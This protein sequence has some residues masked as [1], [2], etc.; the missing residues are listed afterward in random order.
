M[1]GLQLVVLAWGMA[2]FLAVAFI[3]GAFRK[4]DGHKARRDAETRGAWVDRITAGR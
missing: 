2:A 1:S 4:D 3:H